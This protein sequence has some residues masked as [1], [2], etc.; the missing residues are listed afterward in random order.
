METCIV[1]LTFESVDEILW[2]DHSNEISLGVFLHST[3]CFAGFE[4]MKFGIF[5]DFSWIFKAG[6]TVRI[7]EMVESRRYNYKKC[8]RQSGGCLWGCRKQI[9][10]L[11]TILHLF[12][13]LT[14][15]GLENNP[16]TTK[17]AFKTYCIHKPFLGFLVLSS[18]KCTCTI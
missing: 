7:K 15:H 5:L 12:I 8:K 10:V 18:I 16:A 6:V 13:L 11:P 14:I 9:P 3:I 17:V 1:V 4:K 2:C